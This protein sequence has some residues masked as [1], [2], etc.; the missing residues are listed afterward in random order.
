MDSCSRDPSLIQTVAAEDS[1]E[2]V[3]V[4]KE[5]PPLLSCSMQPIDHFCY[6]QFLFV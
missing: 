1:E 4:K 5:L 3:I 6:V 2:S